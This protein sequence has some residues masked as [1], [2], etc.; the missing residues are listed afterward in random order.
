M[1]EA[2][3][4]LTAKTVSLKLRRPDDSIVTR[5]VAVLDAAARR[6]RCD[7][8][9]GDFYL[10]GAY[11]AEF[12]VSDSG[13]PRSF[14]AR[15]FLRIQVEAGIGESAPEPAPPDPDP[16]PTPIDI[17]RHSDLVN[18][19]WMGPRSAYNEFRER[20][21]FTGVDSGGVQRVGYFDLRNGGSQ[22]FVVWGGTPDDHNTPALLVP[23]DKPPI[24]AYRRHSLDDKLRIRV[25]TSAHAL[26]TLGAE[27]EV[28]GFISKISYP[29]IVRKPGTDTIGVI[30]LQ[31]N[32]P[33]NEWWLVRS[34]DYGETWGDPVPL[35][36][37]QYLAMREVAGAAHF[38]TSTW[39]QQASMESA[40]ICYFKVDLST[41]VIT[42]RAGSAVP[43]YNFWTTIEEDLSGPVMV[44]GATM[45]TAFSRS[46]GVTD[47]EESGLGLPARD[48]I[49]SFD[50]HQDGSVLFGTLAKDYPQNGVNYKIRRWTGSSYV[51][52]S[53][54]NSGVPFGYDVSHYVGG[55]A[56]GTTSDE[57]F[58]V[59]EQAG[60]WLLERW[61]RSEGS[62]ALA[63][64]LIQQSRRMGRVQTPQISPQGDYV[65]VCDYHAY[66]H[67]DFTHYLGDQLA[68]KK[69]AQT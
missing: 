13:E 56:F 16:E 55:M 68:V 1:A 48:K 19:W 66:S 3:Y 44:P 36:R 20:L 51:L 4:T 65:L 42:N 61:T 29:K 57:V 9:E 63:E 53:L 15:G 12:V 58:L 28:G 38:M 32:D 24:V 7:W 27:I 10:P 6:V 43:D 25:G 37:K 52:E 18:S 31:D 62:W 14:P 40:E 21:Y 59:R 60:T 45:T 26:D 47:A 39:P 64:T 35:C 50:V 30:V 69:T 33:W 46:P 23:D 11:E 54:V 2:G 22:T 49:R 41:G 67:S 5:S 8:Q 34:D 17:R